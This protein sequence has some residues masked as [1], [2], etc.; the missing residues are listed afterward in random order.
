MKPEWDEGKAA[1]PRKINSS[2]P[3]LFYTLG[4]GGPLNDGG[5]I[6]AKKQKI[7]TIDGKEVVENN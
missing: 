2:H 3:S 7:A 4:F 5:K 6:G 1:T